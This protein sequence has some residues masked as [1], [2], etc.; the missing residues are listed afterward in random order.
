MLAPFLLMA[1]TRQSPCKINL[2]LNVLGRRQDGFHDLETVLQPVSLF[3]EL[4][5]QRGRPGIQL[6]CSE[7]ALPVD[8][9]NL[10]HR[11]AG[12]FLHAANIAEGVSIHLRKRIPLAAGLG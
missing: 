3:D 1:L 11:A 8:S 9:S 5:F 6:T 4:E 10:V 2:L 7:P 12:A